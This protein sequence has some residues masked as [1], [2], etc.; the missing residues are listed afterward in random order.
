MPTETLEL[1]TQDFEY[2]RHG[3]TGLN[4]RLFRPD[5]AGPFPLVIEL[6]GGCWTVGDFSA[7]TD[8]AAYLARKGLAVAAIDFRHAADGYPS[9]LLDINYAVR[10]VKVHA[11]E[12]NG[13]ANRI[14][15]AGVSSGGH[16]AMLSAMRHDDPRYAAIPLSGASDV[17]AAVACVGMS[18]P[19]INP[20]SR[21]R[22][23]L[24]LR[25]GDNP[26]GWTKD[27][28]ERHEMYW[29]DEA[30]MK[31]GNPVT[32]LESGEAV[33]MPPA[34][35]IQGKPDQIHDYHDPDSGQDLNEPER[36]TA[37]Y[38]K[39]GGD[40]NLAYIENAGRAGPASF[41][42]LAAFFLKHLT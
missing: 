2:L 14:G 6:H 3:N 10:W 7:G 13:S 36:F 38:R 26:P 23:A 37:A 16:L 1:V 18:W 34:I 42:P 5:G 25:G 28:P 8:R 19:V 27:I 33:A 24:R 11:G 20:L 39:A 4:L 15:L 12:L 30:A 40:I 29:G 22:H 35:W 9:S 17:D 32:V 41:E 21:Y 31:E